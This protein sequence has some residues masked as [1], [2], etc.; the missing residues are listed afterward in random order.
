MGIRHYDNAQNADSKGSE[1][2]QAILD[3]NILAT[4]VQW[5]SQPTQLSQ[6]WLLSDLEVIL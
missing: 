2:I 5:A 4:I 3:A 1:V 6:K